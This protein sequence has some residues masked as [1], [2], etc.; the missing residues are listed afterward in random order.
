MDTELAYTPVTQAY[1]NGHESQR[2]VLTCCTA[3]QTRPGLNVTL[4]SPHKTAIECFM[5]RLGKLIPL[6]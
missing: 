3:A 5:G 1:G 4:S 2:I 6:P